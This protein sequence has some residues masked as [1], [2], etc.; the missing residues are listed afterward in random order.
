MGHPGM[1]A[2]VIFVNVPVRHI[3]NSEEDLWAWSM[4]K[5][6]NYSVKT[7]NRALVSRNEQSALDG[8]TITETSMTEKQMWYAL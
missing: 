4:E 7:A 5:A 3:P 8:G 2:L 6:D 1:L